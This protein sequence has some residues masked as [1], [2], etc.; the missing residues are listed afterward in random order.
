[1]IR[2]WALQQL[3]GAVAPF[4]AQQNVELNIAKMQISQ[5]AIVLLLIFRKMEIISTFAIGNIL[6]GGI[7]VKNRAFLAF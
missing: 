6:I 3:V 2:F 1:M 5:M 4:T 7:F